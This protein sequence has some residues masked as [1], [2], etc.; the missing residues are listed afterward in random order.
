MS[1]QYL[2]DHVK[3][4]GYV[5]SAKGNIIVSPPTNDNHKIDVVPD[6]R[7]DGIRFDFNDKSIV[8]THSKI[9]INWLFFLVEINC[10]FELNWCENIFGVLQFKFK[11]TYNEYFRY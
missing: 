3:I 7:I 2:E 10:L 5:L 4:E 11:I 6:L 8:L 9:I 1:K